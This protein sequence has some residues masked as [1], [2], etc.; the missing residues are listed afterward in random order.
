[1]WRPK[2]HMNFNEFVFEDLISCSTQ[3]EKPI[4]KRSEKAIVGVLAYA[5]NND[6]I[7]GN[8]KWV[9]GEANESI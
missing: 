3:N 1:M 4:H 7:R 9:I 8:R 2:K 6:M 5:L